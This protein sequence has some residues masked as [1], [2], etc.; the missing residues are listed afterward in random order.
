MAQV[1]AS[2]ARPGDVPARYG[3]EEFA[4]LLP[5]ADTAVACKVAERARV[6]TDVHAPG[7]WRV[8]TVRNVDAWYPAFNVKQGQKLYLAPDKRV[9]VWG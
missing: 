5:G 1:L 7:P 2:A 3:G 4:L 6:A 9:A 8:L